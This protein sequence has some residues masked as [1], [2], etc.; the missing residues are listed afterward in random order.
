MDEITFTVEVADGDNAVVSVRADGSVKDILS[1][2]AKDGLVENT[3]ILDVLHNGVRLDAE[4]RL[5]DTE[6]CAGDVLSAVPTLAEGATAALKQLNVIADYEDWV[7][8]A[9]AA[10]NTEMLT[11]LLERG[12]VVVYPKTKSV[13]GA[14]QQQHRYRRRSDC[15][16]DYESLEE[17]PLAIAACHD[18]TAAMQILKDAGADLHAKD[19]T[20]GTA[21][22]RA[23]SANSCAA[24]ELLCSWG[25][26]PDVRDGTGETPLFCCLARWP[27]ASV[28][29][30]KLG[31]DVNAK[32]NDG[33][34]PLHHVV[35]ASDPQ[36]AITNIVRWGADIDAKD[37]LGD[38]PFCDSVRGWVEAMTTLH[39]LGADIESANTA[40]RRAV[41]HA[42]ESNRVE[43][44]KQLS[45]W[46]ADLDAQDAEGVT[47]LH[48][49][50]REGGRACV[51]ALLAA[52]VGVGRCDSAGATALHYAAAAVPTHE[53]IIRMLIAHGGDCLLADGDG[54]TPCLRAKAE[55]CDR[56]AELLAGCEASAIVAK[57]QNTSHN[58]PTVPDSTE[59]RP[60]S[61]FVPAEFLPKSSEW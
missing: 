25:V 13:P 2:A 10:D 52:G 20:G 40:G 44:L 46:G 43:V 8:R 56:A 24:M 32:D 4:S 27:E 6:L 3:D 54:Y 36:A 23:A 29:L 17:D 39:S 33:R 19:K 58:P 57:Q 60:L 49:A 41:H 18:S 14:Q 53:D 28:C 35:T 9:A 37:K 51:E 16:V 11:L 42:A 26:S 1:A 30:R 47:P 59:N 15:P 50:A 31:A 45:D 5:A 22:H 61:D 12:E 48:L 7:Y 34:T 38:T 55:S 21:L